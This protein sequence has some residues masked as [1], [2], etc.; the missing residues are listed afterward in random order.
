MA[1]PTTAAI[2]ALTDPGGT[3]RGIR[4]VKRVTCGVASATTSYFFE[5]NTYAPGKADWIDF[6]DTA[7]AADVNTGIRAL[8]GV[9]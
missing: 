7:V 1:A 6:A 2:N 4:L 9:A 3:G 5:G 8:F